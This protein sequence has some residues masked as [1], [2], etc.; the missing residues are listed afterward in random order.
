MRRL[1]VPVHDGRHGLRI[2]SGALTQKSVKGTGKWKTINKA[3]VAQKS[4]C[5]RKV[6]S[7]KCHQRKVLV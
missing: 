1:E 6:E 2:E 4:E 7:D 3:R 5:I